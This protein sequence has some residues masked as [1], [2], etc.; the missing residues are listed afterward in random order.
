MYHALQ[1]IQT[2]NRLE[3]RLCIPLL[4][5]RGKR[6]ISAKELKINQTF[7]FFNKEKIMV[8]KLT[9]QFIAN[10]TYRNCNPNSSVKYILKFLFFF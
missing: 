5:K 8:L 7:K 6:K 4:G 10:F 3:L 2:K 1:D 9:D